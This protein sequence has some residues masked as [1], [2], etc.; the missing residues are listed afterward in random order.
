MVFFRRRRPGRHAEDG[1]VFAEPSSEEPVDDEEALEEYVGGLSDEE[2]AKRDGGP[3]D[4]DVA[5]EDDTERFDLGSLRIPQVDGVELQFKG[6][7]DDQVEDV[8]L[9]AGDSALQLSAFAAPRTEGIW[10]E[11]RGELHKSILS[12]GGSAEEVETEYGR[13]LRARIRT[14]NGPA[15]LRFAGFD[16][17]RWMVRAQFQG[18]AAVDAEAGAPL[19][20]CL[21]LLVVRRGKEPRPVGEQLPL[22][23]P[24][25][26]ADQVAEQARAGEA[27]AEPAG[28]GASKPRNGSPGGT[29]SRRG[30]GARSRRR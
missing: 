28:E 12:G 23:L 29:S 7:S 2:R 22:T 15:D 21:D 9:V 24:R 17:P 4:V 16:G 13:E 25:E 10:D 18:R 8:V 1:D 27:K 6:I 26:I 5:P 14:P 20:R 3:Y 19:R 11:V 30:K